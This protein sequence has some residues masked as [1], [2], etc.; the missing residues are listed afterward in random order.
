MTTIYSNIFSNEDIEY[1]TQLPEVVATKAKLDTYNSQG[2]VYFTIHLT[3]TIRNALTTN[4]G[5][6]FSNV[7][8]I[9][10][11]WIKGD[12][13]PHIDTGNK[14]FKNTY[15][16]Y[17]NNSQGEFIVGDENYPIT[18]NTGFVFN[19]GIT[20]KTFNTGTEPRLL[21]GPMN[22]FV[23]PVGTVIN[24]YSNYSDAIAQNGNVIASNT[25]G[26]GILGVVT[27]GSIGSYT[28]WRI[29]IIGNGSM[30]PPTGIYPN[31]FDLD[32]LGFGSANSYTVYPATP[33]FLEGTKVLCQVDGVD[34]YIPIE[35][36]TTETLVKTSLNGY[37]KVELI[38][39]G[40]IQNPAT[41]ERLEN[42]LYKCSP[43]NYP[44]LE[45]DLYITGCH[46]ILVD[47]LTDL[48][49]GKTIKQLG[50]IFVTDKKYR[51]TAYVDERA[52][53]W[54]SEGLY[55]IWHLALE[56]ANDKMNYGIYVNGGLL[57]ETCC[58]STL[59]NKS[60]MTKI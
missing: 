47:S 55:T 5:L 27:S 57:V 46:S 41:N 31:G 25:N 10:M 8:E 16:I 49:R 38:C 7:R 24:Y 23:E 58:I 4:F 1:L 18:K 30:P 33:C 9:P 26:Y 60:N 22:E 11:R 34:S 35:T 12:T 6:D 56:N 14:K 13:A 3:E 29:A 45:N 19:E 44:E 50:K 17:L 28:S 32:T 54:N 43:N 48:Q 53:P 52:E 37:K 20:H 40:S 2:K 51:L 21:V 15:L 42:R 39:K 59:K 36:I